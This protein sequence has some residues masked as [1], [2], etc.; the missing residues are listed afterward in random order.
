ML[1]EYREA[2]VVHLQE[3]V[4]HSLNI[5]VTLR[6][7][8]FR[9]TKMR[10]VVAHV[11][12]SPQAGKRLG[13]CRFIKLPVFMAIELL[14]RAAYLAFQTVLLMYLLSQFVPSTSW[15]AVAQAFPPRTQGHHFDLKLQLRRRFHCHIPCQLT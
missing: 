3:V 6:S 2:A 9:A 1:G 15:N 5:Q 11:A 4:D 8:L 10:N 14:G 13:A 12:H 7:E